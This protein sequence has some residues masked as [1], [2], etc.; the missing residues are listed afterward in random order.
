MSIDNVVLDLWISN[1]DFEEILEATINS[2][3]GN[4]GIDIVSWEG[5]K[6]GT[7]LKQYLLNSILIRSRKM[8]SL[9]LYISYFFNTVENLLVA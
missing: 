3:N 2:L 9:R 7:F 1:N 8:R 5:K 4:V 6:S